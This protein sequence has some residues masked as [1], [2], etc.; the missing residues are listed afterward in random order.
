MFRMLVS[1][2][3]WLAVSIVCAG[4][5]IMGPLAILLGLFFIGLAAI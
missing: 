5:A 1:P 3:V 4:A 2:R